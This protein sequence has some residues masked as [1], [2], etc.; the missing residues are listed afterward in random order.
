MT[1]AL[2]TFPPSY[3]HLLSEEDLD[4]LPSLKGGDSYGVQLKPN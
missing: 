3:L 2:Y 1:T 4:I